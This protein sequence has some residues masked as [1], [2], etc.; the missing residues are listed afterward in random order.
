MPESTPSDSPGNSKRAK[1]SFEGATR[2]K[3]EVVVMNDTSDE[4]PTV[5]RPTQLIS[6]NV[7]PQESTDR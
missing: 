2:P 4:E 1:K 7:V 3:P 6:E 5:K